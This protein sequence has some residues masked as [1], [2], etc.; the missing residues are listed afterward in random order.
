MIQIT[1][2][3][4]D[5][6]FEKQRMKRTILPFEQVAVGEGFFVPENIAN[7]TS[8]SVGAARNGKR[9]GKTFSTA[10]VNNGTWVKRLA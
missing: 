9:L 6:L 3:F 2:K 5:Q 7:R 1:N 10:T 8:V 4:P